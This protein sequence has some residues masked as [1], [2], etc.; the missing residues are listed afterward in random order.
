MNGNVLP[1]V[2]W[3]P[4]AA[5]T[6]PPRKGGPFDLM[7]P[8]VDPVRALTRLR[9]AWK[10]LTQSPYSPAFPK[11]D[12]NSILVTQAIAELN[13]DGPPARPLQAD[14]QGVL[15][16]LVTL[17]PHLSG[18]LVRSLLEF[19]IG[20]EG[21]VFAL[22]ALVQ[23]IRTG[24]GSVLRPAHEKMALELR[25][26]LLAAEARTQ[27]AALDH[28]RAVFAALEVDSHRAGKSSRLQAQALSCEHIASMRNEH[29]LPRRG[30]G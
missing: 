24:R 29:R 6:L 23:M 25:R 5:R 20:L 21:H 4:T 13:A 2:N 30:L 16:S 10:R 12:P 11:D 14:V 17:R 22:S 27:E 19:W 9:K 1:R 28:A 8:K 26:H 7:T 3:G 15:A 18:Q